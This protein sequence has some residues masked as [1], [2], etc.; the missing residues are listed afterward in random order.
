M[1][2]KEDVPVNPRAPSCLLSGSR[3]MFWRSAS[4]SSSRTSGQIPEIEDKDLGA[5]PNGNDGSSNGQTRRFPPPPLT[6]R[7]QQNCKARS[8]LPPLQP[9]SIARRSL[10]EWPKA[11]SDDLG[12]WPQPPTPSGNKSG[13]RLKLDLSSIQRNNDKNG[14][15]LKREKIAFFD[16]ECSKVAEH[17]YLGGDA[18]ARDREILKQN[19]ITH[20]LNCVGFVCPE[21]FKA[22]FVYR[23]LWLQ[24]S[25]SEDITSI[26]YDVFDYFEDVREQGGRVFVHCFQGVSRST[27][28]AIAYLMWRE[29]Q[30]FDDAFQYV[31]AARGIADPNMGFACQL[32]Q[33]QKRVHAFPLSPSSLLRMYRIAPH[34]PYDPLHLVP[35]MLNDP[36]PSLLDSR[37]AFIVQIPSAIYIWIGKNCESVMERDARGAVC[38]IARYER[39]QGPIIVIKEGEEPAYFWDPFSNLLPLVDKSGTKVDVGESAVK[40]CPGE[41]KVE[42]YNVDFEIFQKAIQ[43]GFVPPLASSENEHETHL[44]ARESS[45]SMLRRKFASGVMKEFVS[46]PKILLSRVY[47]DSMMIVHASSPSSTSSSS[48]SSSSSSPPYL[49]PDSISSD[50]STSSKYFSESSLDSPSAVSCS[51]PISS[52]FSNF[53]NLSLVSSQTSSRPKFNSSETVSV[54]L[55]SQPCSQPASSPLKMVSPS[56]AERRGSLSKSLKLPVNDNVRETNDLSCCIV[57]QDVVRI[58]DDTRTSYESDIEIVFDSKLGVR[59]GGDILIQGSSLKISPGRRAN[60]DSR[61]KESTFVNSNYAPQRNHPPQDGFVSAVPNRM[62]ESIPSCPGV[63]QPLVYR[64]P[65]IE[66]MTKF[67]RSDLDS[68]SAF[69]IFSPATV[70]GKNEDR[71]LYFW[72]GRSFHHDKSLIQLDSSRVIGDR[73]DIDWNQVGCDVLTQG[74]LPKNTPIKIV[75][76][77]EEPTEFLALLRTL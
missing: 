39:V 50:S 12:E 66:K 7:S 45:W 5:D 63:V 47:S 33:C 1:V 56:L 30:S 23:T 6:P 27:S 11:S 37:G 4:W 20:V 62:E 51:L 57:K 77:D 76:E 53:S 46:A 19:G 24:D 9:L 54:N 21:Y 68:K 13:E 3:K 61:D 18:V 72:I 59:N 55:T 28:L 42:A 36:S 32:L 44:P 17:I 48:S 10:D 25:P 41:R 75:K 40:I 70:V 14:G 26:L 74:G 71:I 2:G 15:L 29:G 67:N 31:K 34:S 60:A 38:Q 58:N 65:S 52:T 16:K 64:W 43:G 35:K 8:C 73:E 22:D 69:A 49:S